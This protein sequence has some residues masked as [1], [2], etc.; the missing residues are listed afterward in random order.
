MINTAVF[1]PSETAGD[2]E[3]L[4]PSMGVGSSEVFGPSETVGCSEAI[5]PSEAEGSTEVVGPSSGV[6]GTEVPG[7]SE[8]QRPWRI[9]RSLGPWGTPGPG[10]AAERLGASGACISPQLLF[11]AVAFALRR[12]RRREF[13]LTSDMVLPTGVWEQTPTGRRS[14]RKRMAQW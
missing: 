10:I 13:W 4:G 2:P 11:C 9:W 8:A 12:R 6:G 5:E 14:S 3:V 7:S 1:S